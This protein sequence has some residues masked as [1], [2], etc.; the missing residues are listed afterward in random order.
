MII[1]M[2][3]VERNENKL[4]NTHIFSIRLVKLLRDSSTLQIWGD[5][6]MVNCDGWIWMVVK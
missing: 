2:T 6:V 5:F 3:L 1:M 4:F